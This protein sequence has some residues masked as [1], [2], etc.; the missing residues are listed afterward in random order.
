VLSIIVFSPNLSPAAATLGVSGPAAALQILSA[1]AIAFLA[2][3][4]GLNQTHIN[5]YAGLINGLVGD[6]VWSKLDALW[7]FATQD[8]TTAKLNLVSSSFNMTATGAPTFTAD[9]GFNGNSTNY[10]D[11]GAA[12]NSMT[13]FTQNSAHLMAWDLSN[14]TFQNRAIGDAANDTHLYPRF[15]DGSGYFRINN[16]T[17][18][19]ANSTNTKGCFVGS[20]TSSTTL[21]GYKNGT[22][23]V[24][25]G[26]STSGA[27][28]SNHISVPEAGSSAS[29][30]LIAAASVGAGLTATDVTNL[31]NRLFTYLQA[32]GISSP[33]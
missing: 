13:Q 3:T 28:S 12:L 20:R 29:T 9:Q 6:G 27:V 1:Q 21:T 22:Q 32:V 24:T 15:S 14:N 10:L 11:D 23:L 17:G 8:S 5:A 19:N 18:V 2:R 26:A 16:A 25:S 7:A 31:Y 33:I 30:D 4:S